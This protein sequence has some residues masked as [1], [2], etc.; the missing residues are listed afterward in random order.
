LFS[1]VVIIIIFLLQTKVR[2]LSYHLSSVKKNISY[3][4]FISYI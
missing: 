1:R 4:V 3:Q 2:E